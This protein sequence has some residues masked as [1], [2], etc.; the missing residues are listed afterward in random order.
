MTNVTIESL[1]LDGN[2]AHN[3]EL[4][5]NYAGCIFLQDCA[6]VAIRKVVARDY[7]G[8]GI[9]WQICHDVTVEDCESRNHTGLGLHPGRGRSGR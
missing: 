2:K 3:G 1:A 6:D 8:D 7:R 5:G 9:S 4:D